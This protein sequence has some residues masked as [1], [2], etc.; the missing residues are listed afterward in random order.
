MI[1]KI[2]QVINP[3]LKFFNLFFKIFNLKLSKSLKTHI[4]DCLSLF[5]I[6]SESLFKGKLSIFCITTFSYDFDY[7]INVV[8]S[9][10][11][12][13]KN[14]HFVFCNFKVINCT[15]SNYFITMFYEKLD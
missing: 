5:I 10:N 15:T 8:D 12:C 9:C 4:N 1:K 6:K 11:Q 13:F 7:F 3:C 2:L 14:V